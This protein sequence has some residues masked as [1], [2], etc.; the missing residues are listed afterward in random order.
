MWGDPD[1]GGEAV[2]HSP[3]SNRV[4][5]KACAVPT[6]TIQVS[7][8]PQET[9][10]LGVI[11]TPSLPKRT[12]RTATV[13]VEDEPRWWLL[14]GRFAGGCPSAKTPGHGQTKR[15]GGQQVRSSDHLEMPEGLWLSSSFPPPRL[16]ALI[17]TRAPSLQVTMSVEGDRLGG[18]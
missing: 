8:G 14:P 4:K 12:K 15:G 9:W 17:R 18:S 13:T 10:T 7:L 2:R 1:P 6:G 16:Y 3:Q 11:L 5:S